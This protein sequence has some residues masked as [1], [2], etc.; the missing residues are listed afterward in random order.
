LICHVA[1]DQLPLS[2]RERVNKVR[3]C[4]YFSKYGEQV[5]AVLVAL[6]DKYADEGIEDIE[7]I[8]VLKVKPL[9]D[10]GTPM[11]ILNIFGGKPKYL[12]ALAELK[13]QLYEAM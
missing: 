10:I 12:Q 3:Q 9:S 8:D 1:F 11:E 4:N 7:K 5:R 6:L 13:S 2:R